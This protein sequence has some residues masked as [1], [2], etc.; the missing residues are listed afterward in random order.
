VVDNLI[1]KAPCDLLLVKPSQSSQGY[2][3]TVSLAGKWLISV[4]GGPNMERALGFLPSLLSGYPHRESP[5]ILLSKVYSPKEEA[6]N[7]DELQ[8][9][10]EQL[11]N[12][13]SQPITSVPLCSAS[14]SDAIISLAESRHC[15]VV[16]LGSSREGL[17]QN[18][19]HGNIPFTVAH[20]VDSTVLIFRSAFSSHQELSEPE[21]SALFEDFQLS[22]KQEN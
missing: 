2:P 1:E 12:S 10:T 5:E 18:I 3:L 9:L 20:Q 14:I 16:V 22:E 11:K 15:E 4:A 21:E 8:I 19:L 6:S 7:Y 13:L 17:L